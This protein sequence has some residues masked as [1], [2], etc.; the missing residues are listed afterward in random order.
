MPRNGTAGSHSTSVFRFLSNL[1]TIL[2]SGCKNLHS[3]QEQDG[4]LFSTAS[5]AS[6]VCRISWCCSMLCD[7]PEGWD[8]GGWEGSPRG[9]GNLCVAFIQSCLTPCDPVDCSTPGSCVLHCLLEF[10]QIHV[11]SAGDAIQPYH[12]LSPPSPFA[13]DLS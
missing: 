13:L 5:P 11:H 3:H 10:A 8:E 9:R 12:P 4:S 6:I 2:H 7:D 1:H